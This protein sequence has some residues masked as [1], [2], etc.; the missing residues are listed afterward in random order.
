[1]QQFRA[2]GL[3]FGHG[4][5]DARDEAAYLTLHALNLPLGWNAASRQRVNRSQ[6]AAVMALF[7]RRILERKPAAYLTHEAWLGDFRF[8]VDERVIVPRS[9]IAELL[10]E[11]LSPWIPQP[12]RIRHSLDL[13][14]GSGCLAVLLAHS[15]PLTDI[16]ATDVSPAA[17]EV[18]RRNVA[19]YRLTQR[20]RLVQSDLFAALGR[21]RYDLIVANP[22][23]VRTA[24]MQRL[25]PEHRSEP[26][27]ALA[28]GK[29]GL[30][31]VHRI[32]LGAWRHLEPGGLLVVEVGHNRR[33]VESAYPHLAF[34]WAETSGGDDCV[35]LLTREQLRP[36]IPV[37]GRAPEA[38]RAHRRRRAGTSARA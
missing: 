8:Y 4:T 15:F 9:F 24:I 38:G 13:G 34:T 16:D 28:G 29:D 22:P 33:R 30:G 2:H 35:F 19:D 12:G 36:R 10:R 37:R 11:D 25:P 32:L 23:Y 17:L 14:T 20:I 3:A 31:V 7:A 26:P 21:R 27:L 5:V 1:M 6:A 18:A